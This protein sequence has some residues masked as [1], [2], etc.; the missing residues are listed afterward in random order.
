[1]ISQKGLFSTKIAGRTLPYNMFCIVGIVIL[2][3]NIVL[4]STWPFKDTQTIQIFMAARFKQQCPGRP[5]QVLLGI[6]QFFR[7]R[8]AAQRRQTLGNQ[9]GALSCSM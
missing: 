2:L 1:M 4:A 7:H 6:G 3:F 9:A 5:G 8:M